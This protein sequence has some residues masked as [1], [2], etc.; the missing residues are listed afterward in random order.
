MEAG[1]QEEISAVVLPENSN[2]VVLW[3]SQD[4]SVATAFSGKVCAVGDGKAEIIAFSQSGSVQGSV[5]VQVGKEGKVSEE[6]GMNGVKT[7]KSGKASQNALLVIGI[8]AVF[9][10]GAGMVKNRREIK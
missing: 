5:M 7:A 4:E 8:G 3:K 2:D 1:A 6:K 10:V 9:M